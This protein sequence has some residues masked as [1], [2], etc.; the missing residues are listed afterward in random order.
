VAC[1]SLEYKDVPAQSSGS[2][3]LSGVRRLY[4]S[5]KRGA[6]STRSDVNLPNPSRSPSALHA[7]IIEKRGEREGEREG[8]QEETGGMYAGSRNAWDS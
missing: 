3:S 5:R 1:V 8:E 2:F 4:H 6:A 7:C